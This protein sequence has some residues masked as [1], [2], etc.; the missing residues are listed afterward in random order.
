MLFEAIVSV[1][2]CCGSDIKMKS[3][4]HFTL[5]KTVTQVDVPKAQGGAS[6]LVETGVGVCWGEVGIVT[7]LVA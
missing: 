1:V 5:R 6:L 2:L 4:H 7:A 3:E